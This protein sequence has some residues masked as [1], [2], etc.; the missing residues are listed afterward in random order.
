MYAH[1]I[2][3][4]GAPERQ[5]SWWGRIYVVGLICPPPSL[6]RIGSIYLPKIGGQTSPHVPISSGGP[7]W[8]TRCVHFIIF[9]IFSFTMK[10]Y[11]NNQLSITFDR[12]G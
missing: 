2:Q 6:I 11:E 3:F 12:Q 8:H 5:T 9:Q 1:F 10:K 7:D 4:S